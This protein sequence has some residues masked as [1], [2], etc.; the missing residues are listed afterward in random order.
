MNP[1]L[2][3]KDSEYPAPHDPNLDDLDASKHT[4]LDWKGAVDMGALIDQVYLN[5]DSLPL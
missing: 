1:E 3:A 5:V 2:E 4:H